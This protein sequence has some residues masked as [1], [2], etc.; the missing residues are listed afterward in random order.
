MQ[1]QT[2]A[3]Y[4]HFGPS[5]ELLY[6][7]ISLSAVVRLSQHR[8]GS[9][10]FQKIKRVSIEHFAT[11]ADALKAEREA[12]SNEKPI[13]NINLKTKPAEAAREQVKA[14]RRDLVSRL[15]RFEPAYKIQEVADMLSMSTSSV[16]AMMDS[17]QL[18]FV[19]FGGSKHRYRITGWQLIDFI[20]RAADKARSINLSRIFDVSA[21][22]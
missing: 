18:G 2:T 17:G 11:R 20:E 14:S 21:T 4:R 5:D 3:L 9:E 8:D 22:A 15:V 19:D 16:R 1:E 12:V 6:V 13:H 7:G 10:W